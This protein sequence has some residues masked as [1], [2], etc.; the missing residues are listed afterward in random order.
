MSAYFE[1]I[2]FI[3][4]TMYLF[5]LFIRIRKLSKVDYKDMLIFDHDKTTAKIMKH[6]N[7]VTILLPRTGITRNI[8]RQGLNTFSEIRMAEEPI[9][10]TD[11][12]TNSSSTIDG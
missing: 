8:M 3:I 12:I 9:T 11:N 1:E 2:L 10:V 6:M 4:N 7:V 5:V